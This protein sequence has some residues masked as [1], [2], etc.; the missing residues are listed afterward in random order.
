MTPDELNETLTALKQAR[1]D[2]SITESGLSTLEALEKGSW[3][4]P[5]VANL[6]QGVSGN[7]SDEILG[8]L[9]STFTGADQ[10]V[11]TALERNV[12][13]ESMQ[14][15]P[16]T[17]VG[18]QVLGSI[19]LTRGR[20]GFTQA[21]GLGALY[22]SG[23]AEGGAKER[24]GEGA[25]GMAVAGA[26]YPLFNIALRPIQTI[27]AGI[28]KT[29]QGP[30]ALGQ[31]Q[32]RQLIKEAIQNDAKTLDEAFLYILNKNN[33]GKPF[34]LADLEGG[35]TQQL[36]DVVNVLPGKG[37]GIA[38]NFLRKRDKG[39]LTRLTS[40]LQEAFGQNAGYFAE[41]KALQNARF[42]TG[43]KLYNLAYKRNI[44]I[45]N[46]LQELLK[47]PSMANAL[48]K[49]KRIAAE[50]SVD[51]PNITLKNGKLVNAK[52]K[53]ITSLPTRFL[54]Y[55]KR[56]LDDEIFIGRSPT[57]G[58]GK[59]YL[60]AAKGTRNQF[61]T[62]LDE[63]N[64]AYKRARNYWSG[65]SSVMDAMTLGNSFLKGDV[66]ELADE[67]AN[68]SSSELEAFRLGAMQNMLNEIESGAERTSVQRL[69]KSPQREKLMRL[70]FPNTANGKIKADKFINKLTD[71]IVMRD[72]SKGIL[73]G[74]QTAVRGEF[75][76]RIKE[77]AQ[78]TPITGITELVSRAISKDF[79]QISQS[80]TS[81]VAAQLANIL[82]ETNPT[83]LNVIKRDL[84]NKGIK[85]V[86]KNYIPSLL[87]KLSS[88]IVN[89]QIGTVS[90]VNVEQSQNIIPNPAQFIK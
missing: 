81:E 54:H 74:S 8:Y 60:N 2:N 30:V 3:T 23:G 82:T 83:K 39:I 6:L 73:S 67:I 9:R 59:D 88:L 56:G 50:E 28:R 20:G 72:T 58:S 55:V 13:K 61:L 85:N 41:F 48:S 33:N 57:S 25:T 10:D 36:L 68:F 65:K 11:T 4:S 27:G 71:E 26:A 1:A 77:E 34:T 62:F 7:Y 37:K 52:G 79:Q 16:V 75:A 76:S 84:A 44:K 5:F 24:V 40:D 17:T 64:P 78:R 70:T 87:P 29:I 43:N 31:Q 19:P 51:L 15:S 49:A 47:R 22:G 14:E 86:V 32:A 80:Q 46:D 38:Q 18:T 45:N 35:N 12:V 21:L 42:Q 89:P 90:A 63:N 53:K 69:L 66:N